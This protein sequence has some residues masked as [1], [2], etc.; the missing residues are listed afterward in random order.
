M[1]DRTLSIGRP[2]DCPQH[3]QPAISE[4]SIAPYNSRW[5]LIVSGVCAAILVA[6]LGTILWFSVTSPKLQR[7]GE[8]DRALDLMVSRMLDAQDSLRRAPRWQQ[9]LSDWTMGSN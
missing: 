8:P 1:S 6:A 3:D 9:W 4:Q 7:I 5:S 2:S